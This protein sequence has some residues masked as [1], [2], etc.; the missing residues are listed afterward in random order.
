MNKTLVIHPDDRSTDFLKPIYSNITDATVI[1]GG[2]SKDQVRQL[3]N[4]HDR[5]FMMGHGSPFGLFSMNKFPSPKYFGCIIDESMVEALQNKELIAIWCNC[6]QFMKRHNLK[7]LYSGMF[8]SEV[9]EA[10]YCGLPGTS[11]DI[12]DESNNSF[13]H[14]FGEVSNQ[15][16]YEAYHSMMNNYESLAGSNPVALYNSNRLYLKS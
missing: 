1:N 6:D 5:I 9:G 4:E 12:I 15:P 14:W 16:L 7:G 11:Q 10:E 2:I 13:A 3:I 8:I